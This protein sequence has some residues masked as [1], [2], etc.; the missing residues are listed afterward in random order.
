MR[1]SLVSLIFAI[2]LFFKYSAPSVALPMGLTDIGSLEQDAVVSLLNEEET[3]ND[4]G[5]GDMAT[6][7]KGPRVIVV[8][9]DPSVWRGLRMLSAGQPLYKWRA[10]ENDHVTEHR[11]PGQALNISMLKRDTM[12]CMVGRVYRPCWEV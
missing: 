3:E 10:N 1:Q 2:A 7:E 4:H 8:A 12:R 9:T 11:G 5:Y 6:K